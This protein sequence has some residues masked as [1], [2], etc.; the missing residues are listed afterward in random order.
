[1]SVLDKKYVVEMPDGSKWSVPV[2]VI[3]ESHAEYYYEKRAYKSMEESLKATEVL[4]EDDYEI[5]DWAQNNM[6][7]ADVKHEA[8]QVEPPDEE[9]DWDDGWSNGEVEIIDE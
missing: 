9:V 1:M 6:D 4:F 7:W 2:R 8:W 5:Q 3:A